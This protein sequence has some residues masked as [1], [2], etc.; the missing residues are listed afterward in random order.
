LK[1]IKVSDLKLTE[2]LNRIPFF[3][4][5]SVTERKAFFTRNLDFLRCREG[6]VIIKEGDK[7]DGFY[8]ILSGRGGVYLNHG[9]DR[10]A[11]VIG[12]YFIGEGAFINNQPH[13]ATVIADIETY[14]LR[15][16]RETLVRFP[17]SIREMVK[18]QI[19]Y[20]MAMRLRDMNVRSLEK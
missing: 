1:P 18:D 11:E 16:D 10:V 2:I 8:I 6:E 12:G 20:G 7:Q 19:I 15:L 9:K 5:F 3:K 13:S 14:V 17:A 4:K